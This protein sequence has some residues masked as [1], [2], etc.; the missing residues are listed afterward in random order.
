[1]DNFDNDPNVFEWQYVNHRNEYDNEDFMF[2]PNGSYRSDILVHN[3]L[4]NNVKDKINYNADQFLI[5]ASYGYANTAGNFAVN[6]IINIMGWNKEHVKEIEPFSEVFT[7][8]NDIFMNL[9]YTLGK[10]WLESYVQLPHSSSYTPGHNMTRFDD[11]AFM[12][13]APDMKKYNLPDSGA[14]YLSR[15]NNDIS[16]IILTIALE[17]IINYKSIYLAVILF[18]FMAYASQ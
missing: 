5:R 1:M 4:I 14:S 10:M 17:S 16:Y 12:N 13:F 7:T 15:F 2:N 18:D 6:Y 8:K 3:F 9:I 11:D